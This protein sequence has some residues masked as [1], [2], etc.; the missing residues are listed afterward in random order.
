[1]DKSWWKGRIEKERGLDMYIDFLKKK[2]FIDVNAT[3]VLRP[4]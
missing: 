1:M 3:T 4:F 2:T